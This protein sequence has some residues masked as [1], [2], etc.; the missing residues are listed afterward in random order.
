MLFLQIKNESM[1]AVNDKTRIDIS[2]SF[3]SG[4]EPTIENFFIIPETGEEIDVTETMYLDW[5]YD[6]NT[7]YTVIVK[8]VDDL[9]VEYTKEATITVLSETEDNLFSN[10]SDIIALE[11]DI[12]QW[13]QDGRDSFL[14]KHREAQK[15]I[16]NELDAV[17]IWKDNGERYVA[18]DI[19]DIQEF[20][21]WSKYVTLRIIFEGISNAI[22]DVFSVKATKY[23]S[24]AVQAKKRATFR[25][26]G[27]SDGTNDIHENVNNFSGRLILR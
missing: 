25:L 23:E 13:V 9:A 27:N 19:V 22:D 12:L 16:L 1:V 14:D 11:T 4:L 8:A 21:D 18:G 6:T 5:V 26:D 24:H 17:R 7:A 2:K 10:D 20:K 15:E 3:I